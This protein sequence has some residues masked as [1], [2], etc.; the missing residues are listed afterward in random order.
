MEK[1][2][3]TKAKANLQRSFYVKEIDAKCAKGYCLLVKKNK[4]DTY[5]H[6]NKASKDKEMAKFHNSSS[7]NYL[8]TQAPKKDKHSCQRGHP[9]TR[10]NAI[11]VVKK[12]KDKAKDL[13]HV[14]CYTCKQKGHYANKCPE[15][16]KNWWQFWRPLCL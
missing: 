15:K 14:E 3:D 11:K 5:Q 8:Q 4:E 12:D 7:T 2:G 16:S 13:G 9:A 10:V 1:A 6:H